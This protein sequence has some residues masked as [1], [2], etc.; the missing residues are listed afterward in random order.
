MGVV[1]FWLIR[2]AV[3]EKMEEVW[4]KK[5]PDYALPVETGGAD[6]EKH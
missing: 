4:Q 3:R 6:Q 1:G 2:P 5:W